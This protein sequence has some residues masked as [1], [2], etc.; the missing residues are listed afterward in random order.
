MQDS[1]RDPATR[2]VFFFVFR[3]FTRSQN[4][5]CKYSVKE[6]AQFGFWR[7]FGP[8]FDFIFFTLRE[9]IR[10]LSE[11]L[12]NGLNIENKNIYLPTGKKY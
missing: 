4:T 10:S 3:G 7:I 8:L 5:I 12:Q 11:S 6:N 2:I 1:N 9:I